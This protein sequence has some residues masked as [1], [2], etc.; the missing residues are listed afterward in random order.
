MDIFR[1]V[2]D[3][4]TKAVN[5]V[6]DQNRK[7]ALINRLKIV[8]GNEKETKARAYIALG[9]YYY[10]RMRDTEN[11]ETEH[12]CRA[13]DNAD[14]RLKKA[15]TRLDELV[16][17]TGAEPESDAEKESENPEEEPSCRCGDDAF[18]GEDS[19][20]CGSCEKPESAGEDA[21][22]PVEAA[23]CPENDGETADDGIGADHPFGDGDGNTGG[24]EFPEE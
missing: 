20:C 6:V 1:N 17:P 8:I 16:R 11:E 7:T 21:V 9:E 18:R 24:K 3:S 19:C 2:A 5:F 22:P 13:V 14:R 4:V 23:R 12:L 15:Y 10:E